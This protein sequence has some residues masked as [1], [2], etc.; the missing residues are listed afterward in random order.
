MNIGPK[1]SEIYIFELQYCDI[2][3]LYLTK[4]C[5]VKIDKQK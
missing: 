3:N 4:I 5:K 1:Y 2:I